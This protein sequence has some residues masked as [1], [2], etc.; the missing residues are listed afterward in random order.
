MNAL[1]AASAVGGAAVA[2]VVVH[3]GSPGWQLARVV[4]AAALTM[5]V[6]LVTA[7]AEDRWRGRVAVGFGAVLAATGAGLLPHA[8]KSAGTVEVLAGPVALVAGLVLVVGG[9]VAAT[10]GRQLARRLGAAGVSL[11]I[12]GMTALIVAPAVMATNA[13][14]PELRATPHD[15]GLVYEDVAVTTPDDVDLAG[16]YIPSKNRAAVVLL[17]GAGSTRSSVLDEV[18]VL[19][20]HD[21]GVLMIDARGHG[22]SEGQSMDFG[23]H[24]DTDV[25]AATAFLADRPEVDA[26]RIGLVGLSM[27]G[28]EA[29]GASGLDTRIA[30]VVAEGATARN[31]ADEAWLS[32]EFGVRGA[33]Q[34]QLERLQ[35][36]LIDFLTSASVPIAGRAAVEAS[37]AQYLLITAGKVSDEGHAAAHMATGAP[38]RVQIWTVAGAGHTAG[39]ATAP[40][41]WEERVVSFLSDALLGSKP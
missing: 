7:R 26:D 32:E 30:A 24:G 9:T 1:P 31:A 29:I 15:R 11:V 23:W 39:L 35:D 4:G 21:F 3:D 12:V 14:R 13:P 38:D 2:V 22:E 34:E 18:A 25:P 40:E 16:W 20:H 27:G 33:F 37:D 5:V 28:E 8:V 41:E 10:T 17:H 36:R 6:V 19:A